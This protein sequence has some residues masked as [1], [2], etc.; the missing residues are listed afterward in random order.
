MVSDV[1]LLL[2][3]DYA[4]VGMCSIS[5]RAEELYS[6]LAVLKAHTIEPLCETVLLG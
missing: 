4:T 5:C 1:A 3:Y 6:N 2:I